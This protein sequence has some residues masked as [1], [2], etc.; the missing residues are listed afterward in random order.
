MLLLSKGARPARGETPSTGNI[1]L[2][3]SR[4]GVDLLG[5]A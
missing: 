1:K 3:V 2:A 4:A 5:V